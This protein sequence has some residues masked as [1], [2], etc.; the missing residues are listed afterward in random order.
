MRNNFESVGTIPISEI[1]LDQKNYRLGPIDTQKECIIA[2]FR[3]FDEKMVKIATHIAK[4]GLSP[5]PIVVSK[6]ENGQWRVRDGNRRITALKILN[7]TAE[8]PDDHYRKVFEAIRRNA[9]PGTIPDSVECLTADEPTIIEYVRLEHMGLQNGIGQVDWGPRAKDNLQDDLGG[10]LNYKLSSSVLEYLSNRG[11]EESRN[12]K[13]T[14]IQRL[15]QDKDISDRIGIAW[16]GNNLII[17]HKEDEVFRLLRGIV[18]DFAKGDKTV[19]DI[20][21][22]TDRMKYIDEFFEER[23][24]K[25]PTPLDEPKYPTGARVKYTGGAS[26]EGEKVP[27]RRKAPWDRKRVIERGRGIPVPLTETKLN[28]ILVELSSKIDVR[29]ATIAAAVLVRLVAE[30]SVDA[31]M[32]KISPSTN[33]DDLNLGKKIFKAAEIMHQ[34]QTIG[35]K[36]CDQLKKMSSSDVFLSAH[37]LNAWVHNPTYIP[38]PRSVCTFWD[39]IRFFL[40]ECWK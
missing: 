5:K 18:I 40:V 26:S 17:T 34:N 20:Y 3:E 24:F 23:G 10:K 15:V 13:I 14:N 38:D 29:E 7:N 1:L 8:A 11:V 33:L 9:E 30:F 2:M 19:K 21:L 22:H 37:T 4:Y 27:T 32:R 12:V 39:N 25:V 16:D 35:K 36:Q 28:S 31:Y 6:N